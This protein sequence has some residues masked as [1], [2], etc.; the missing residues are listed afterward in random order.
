[1][2]IIKMGKRMVKPFRSKQKAM[3]FGRKAKKMGYTP[4]MYKVNNV[5]LVASRKKR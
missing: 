1:M 3:K 4:E 5:Y 2:V